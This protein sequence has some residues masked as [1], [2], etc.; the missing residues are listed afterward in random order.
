MND[1]DRLQQV[2]SLFHAA[3]ARPPGER[4]AFLDAVCGSD[5][6]LLAQVNTLLAAHE[7]SGDFI[8]RPAAENA[9]WLTQESSRSLIG[10]RLGSYR[11]LAP[12]GKG[13]MGEVFAAED[14]RIGRRVALKLLPAEFTHDEERVRRFERE[15]RAV[16][17]LNHPNIIT[18]HELG[19]DGDVNFLVTELVEGETMRQRLARG[20]LQPVEALAIVTQIASALS[21]AHEAG[22]VHR[23]IKPE[24]VMMRP[25]GIVKVLDFGLAKI[26][27]PRL[28]GESS[29]GVESQTELGRALG[30]INYM[31]PEQALGEKIDHRT[32]IFSLGVTL[33][34]LIAG[35]PPFRGAT[36][37]ATYDLLLNK[38]PEPITRIAPALPAEWDAV[39]DRALA[40]DRQDRYQTASEM[41]NE[42]ESLRMASHT[43]AQTTG[44]FR[45]LRRGALAVLIVVALAGVAAW[46]LPGLRGNLQNVFRRR[47]G[48]PPQTTISFLLQWGEKGLRDG[49]F[50]RPF[51]VA[52]D[53]EGRIYV[54]DTRNH[55][56]QKFDANGALLGKWGDFGQ[57]PGQLNGPLSVAFDR[58]G[59]VYVTDTDNHRIQKFDANGNLLACWGNGG[60]GD[61]Q[62]YGPRAAALDAAGNVYV[63]DTNN[64]RVQKLN[65]DGKFTAKWG[66]QGPLDGEFNTP[67]G[68][69]VDAFGA[70]FVADSS[71][72][73]VQKFDAA[74]RFLLK[75]GQAG[76]GPGQFASPRAVAV[77]AR[78]EVYV[79]DRGNN[80]VQKFDANGAFITAWGRPGKGAGEF[81]SPCSL[82][83]AAD[84]S[85]YVADTD[86]HR[87]QKFREQ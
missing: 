3:L 78:G 28:A 77:N 64:N 51:G 56:I 35:A 4:A 46:W 81:N 47:P 14:T 33:Y 1:A 86:N 13:G 73:R 42:L 65:P 2:E 79:V 85:I 21:A 53:A 55:R 58:S 22:I 48:I 68:V 67:L 20:S 49:Q 27:I 57:Q 32:D 80:R 19:R 82:A 31:S 44:R 26:S 84:G 74:G 12:L 18:L 72:F 59:A 34:E 7:R 23:D 87:I 30:T 17:L 10:R 9:V 29:F 75:W 63:I 40:K 37:A 69:A 54:A 76:K 70:V 8:D 11:V 39:L 38:K 5:A 24:N 62:F 61:G 41:K 45:K 71:N 66:T 43:P 36:P 50:D 6:K 52:V 25:D 15:A 16:S 60:D 83:M